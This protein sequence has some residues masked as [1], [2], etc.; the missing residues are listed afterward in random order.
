MNLTVSTAAKSCRAQL[1]QVLS[2]SLSN[3]SSNTPRYFDNINN[4][5]W[6]VDKA[7]RKA[8]DGGAPRSQPSELASNAR[9]L[10]Q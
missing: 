3:I 9:G 6:L 7:C 8:S 1:R 2:M 5:S 4:H 10:M